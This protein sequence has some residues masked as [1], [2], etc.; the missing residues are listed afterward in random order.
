M[1]DHYQ[2]PLI[3]R[4]IRNPTRKHKLPKGSMFHSDRIRNY[5][6]AEYA[7]VLQEL[8]RRDRNLFRQR[9]WPNRWSLS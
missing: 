3:S 1:D 7:G 4:A 6:S 8:G 5:M 9:P 2:A